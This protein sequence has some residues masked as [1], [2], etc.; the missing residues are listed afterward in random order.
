MTLHWKRFRGLILQVANAAPVEG[1]RT[2]AYSRLWVNI[3]PWVD[4]ARANDRSTTIRT[5]QE[6]CNI[7]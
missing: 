6:H 7:F 4:Q 3:R 1:L 2:Q 5:T